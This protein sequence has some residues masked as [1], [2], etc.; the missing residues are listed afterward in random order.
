VL[1]AGLRVLETPGGG[2]ELAVRVPS[3]AAEASATLNGRPAPAE[4]GGGQY[5]RIRR[6]WKPGDELTVEFPLTAR[7]IYPDPG[8]DAVHSCAAFERAR[9]STF[10][11][12]VDVPGGGALE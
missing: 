1:A 10:S 8:I 11:K 9:P 3:W 4:P 5:L 6:S 12:E 2:T 7:T